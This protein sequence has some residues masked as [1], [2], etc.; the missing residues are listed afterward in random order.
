V[1]PAVSLVIAARNAASTLRDTLRSLQAQTYAG[2]EALIVD[3]RSTDATADV[4]A[5]YATNDARFVPLRGGGSGVSAARN[6]GIASARGKWLAFLDADDWLDPSFLSVMLGALEA[7]PEA[8]VASC[9]FRRAMPSGRHGPDEGHL[10]EELDAFEVVS[11]SCTVAIHTVLVAR[12]LVLEVGGFDPSLNTCEDWDLWARVARTGVPWLRVNQALS[13]Y[14]V[15]PGSLSRNAERCLADARIVL[16]RTFSPDPR[17]PESAA[18]RKAP[19]AR[20]GSRAHSEAAMALWYGAYEAARGGDVLP[21]ARSLAGLRTCF[22]EWMPRGLLTAVC[23]GLQVVPAE[24]AARWREFGPGVTRLIERAGRLLSDGVSARRLQYAFEQL[25][26][27]YDDLAEPRELELTLGLRVDLRHPARCEP[28]PGVDRIYAYFCDG[29]QIIGVARFG[30]LGALG[31]GD[32]WRAASRAIGWEPRR[33]P[34]RLSLGVPQ[35]LRAVELAAKRPTELLRSESRV[36]LWR[37]AAQPPARGARGQRHA[38]QLARARKLAE[39]AIVPVR[40]SAQHAARQQRREPERALDLRS[41]ESARASEIPILMYHRVADVGPPALARYRVTSEAFRAQMSWLHQQGYHALG[42]AELAAHLEQRVPFRGRPVLITFDD[43]YLDFAENAWPILR[44]HALTAEVFIVTGKV[45]RTADWDATT[46]PAAP[47][48][49]AGTIAR[50]HAEGVRFGSHLATHRVASGLGTRALTHELLE[51]RAVLG[52]WL[53]SDIRSLAAPYGVSDERLRQLA[54]ECG[55]S[56]LL[57]TEDGIANFASNPFH[58]PRIE[59]RGDMLLDE[60]V[61]RICAS[62]AISERER[63]PT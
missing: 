40:K 9:L 16:G 51:S 26:L 19:S 52:G 21:F 41:R 60:F 8:R 38:A 13:F 35:A 3:D 44:E 46:E 54:G 33:L 2:W 31:P 62:G 20:L 45:G 48:M 50:L 36:K 37:N 22:E 17:V 57:T 15:T 4:I 58:L 43:G 30:V 55:Y 10:P 11:R 32:W 1:T 5:T 47:L 49:D 34:E 12:T 53:G 25:V 18:T 61:G 63:K 59:V 23:V 29:A 24:A 39:A 42:A 56:I 7:D 28:P 14:R 27:D 6:L